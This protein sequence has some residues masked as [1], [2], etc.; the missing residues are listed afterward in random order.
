MRMQNCCGGR[1]ACA[2]HGS[3]RGVSALG[4]ERHGGAFAGVDVCGAGPGT[5]FEEQTTTLLSL[6]AAYDHRLLLWTTLLRVLYR[7]LQIT[8]PSPGPPSIAFTQPHTRHYANSPRPRNKPT[9]PF[10][11]LCCHRNRRRSMEYMG[12]GYLPQL[13]SY[14]R[15]AA[16]LSLHRHVSLCHVSR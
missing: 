4:C 1:L 10:S 9:R 16:P 14:R 12:P 13:G 5:C 8:K 3:P 2:M 15:Y 6:T 7:L 11:R